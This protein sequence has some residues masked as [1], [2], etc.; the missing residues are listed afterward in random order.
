MKKGYE[1][2]GFEPSC[3]SMLTDDYL[4]LT[5]DS[6][7]RAVAEK[8]YLFEEYVAV[9]GERDEL[10]IPFS[11]LKK[12]ILVHGHCHQK[13]LGGIEPVL[14]ALN[15]PPGYTARAI[16]SACCGM[17]GA[18][19]YEAEHYEVSLKVGED[20]LLKVV[21]EAAPHVEVAAAGLSC[22]QQIAHATGR[23]ARHPVEVL[24]D[25]VAPGRGL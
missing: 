3:V 20:R 18:F 25:A 8:S 7:A 21:R 15:L 6:R 16:D 19:G 11:N 4:D 1:I 12:E 2:V 17:A 9:L 22:R 10:E 5:P 14:A 23:Q 24:W 13:A